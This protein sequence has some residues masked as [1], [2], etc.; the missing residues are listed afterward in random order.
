[1]TSCLIYVGSK[2][3]NLILKIIF[4]KI[5]KA[6]MIDIINQIFEIEQKLQARK[7]TF[8]D[9]NLAR[10]K[11]EFEVMGYRVINP[12]HRRYQM[13]DADLDATVSGDSKTDLKV[14]RVLKPVIYLRTKNDELSLL[15]KGIVIVE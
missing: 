2:G 1:M 6:R 7:E 4:C 3:I 8:A 15:Q 9:R 11:H 5:V 12:I 13:T 14:T 10:L